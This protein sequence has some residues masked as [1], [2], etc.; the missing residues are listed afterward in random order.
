MNLREQPPGTLEEPKKFQRGEDRCNF[1][2]R[3]TDHTEKEHRPTGAD[4]DHG[5]EPPRLFLGRPQ[6]EN[7]HHGH[8]STNRSQPPQR[9]EEHR[10]E[11]R[12][13]KARV[14]RNAF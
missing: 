4:S 5:G 3:R 7:L 11:N 13:G 2:P 8:R 10:A 9:P 12:Q 1:K 6:L 14:R